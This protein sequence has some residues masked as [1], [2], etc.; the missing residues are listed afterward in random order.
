MFYIFALTTT[1]PPSLSFICSPSESMFVLVLV[2]DDV[3]Q[4]LL[5]VVLVVMTMVE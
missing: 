3:F 1:H 4:V 2:C 5:L